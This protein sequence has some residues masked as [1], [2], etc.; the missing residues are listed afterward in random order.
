MTLVLWH[1]TKLMEWEKRSNDKVGTKDAEDAKPVG[2]H[3]GNY[4]RK[5]F[6]TVKALIWRTNHPFF[7]VVM[8]CPLPK[9][10]RIP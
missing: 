1:P 8:A 5:G 6:S 3:D 2:H 10:F 9:K 7:T 4:Q